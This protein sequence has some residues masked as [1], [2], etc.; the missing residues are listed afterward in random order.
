MGAKVVAYNFVKQFADRVEDGSKKHTIRNFGLRRHARE[1][2]GLQLYYGMRTKVCRK[3]KDEKCSA[4]VEIQIM[5]STGG[6]FSWV[7]VDGRF[8]QTDQLDAFAAEDGFES[9]SQMEL[10]FNELSGPGLFKGKLIVWNLDSVAGKLIK[11]APV[12]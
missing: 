4:S 6:C 3:L 2:D 9:L 5:I 10:F 12:G 8:L 11:G 1:G 7:K